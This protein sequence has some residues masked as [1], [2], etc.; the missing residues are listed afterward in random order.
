MPMVLLRC[1]KDIPER[2]KHIYLKA[3]DDD[4]KD[5]LPLANSRFPNEVARFAVR[6][7]LL[8]ASSKTRSK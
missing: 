6:N 1:D 3:P 8:E 7:S 5:F 4:P 2:E